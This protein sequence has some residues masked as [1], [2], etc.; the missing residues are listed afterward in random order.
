MRL[1]GGTLT[2]APARSPKHPDRGRRLPTMSQPPFDPLNVIAIPC[3]ME[4]V[5]KPARVRFTV[6]ITIPALPSHPGTTDPDV[7]DEQDSLLEL[8]QAAVNSWWKYH[9][10]NTVRVESVSRTYGE[11]ES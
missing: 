9:P 3:P 7:L 1:A 4:R 8:L 11:V 5:P 2:G 10:E 6:E